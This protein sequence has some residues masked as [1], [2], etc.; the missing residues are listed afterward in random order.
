M[1]EVVTDLAGGHVGV[2]KEARNGLAK[3]VTDEA[4]HRRLIEDLPPHAP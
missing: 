2:V 1:L 3:H 4:I